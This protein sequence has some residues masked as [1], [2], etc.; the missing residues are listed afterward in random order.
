MFDTNDMKL[1]IIKPSFL[2]GSRY[3]VK[4]IKVPI[5]KEKHLPVSVNIFEKKMG[6]GGGW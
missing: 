4:C 2:V 5:G 1:D 6:V 3:F